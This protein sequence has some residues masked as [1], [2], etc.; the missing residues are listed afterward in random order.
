MKNVSSRGFTLIEL[1]IVSAILA[2]LAMIALPKFANLIDRSREASMKG[3]LGSL[4]SALSI[5]YADNDGVYPRWHPLMGG[6]WLGA[7]LLH[8]KYI[9][10]ERVEFNPPRYTRAN[11]TNAMRLY[12]LTGG[13]IALYNSYALNAVRPPPVHT[14]SV[15]PSYFV[16]GPNLSD[17]AVYAEFAMYPYTFS[18]AAP[19]LDT[20]GRAWSLW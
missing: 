1:M 8:D 19:M 20:S 5:Y 7:V 6:E 14:M 17:P 11:S 12:S 16:W 10:L 9:D 13:S 4:R 15:F 3:A 2:I 18:P